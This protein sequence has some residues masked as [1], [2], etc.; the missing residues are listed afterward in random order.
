VTIFLCHAIDLPPDQGSVAA[1]AVDTLVRGAPAGRI[2]VE[3]PALV[4]LY[5]GILAD[6]ARRP[7]AEVIVHVLGNVDTDAILT[8]IGSETASRELRERLTAELNAHSPRHGAHAKPPDLPPREPAPTRGMHFWESEPVAAPVEAATACP[9]GIFK[10]KP[11]DS[12]VRI[13][14]VV[15]NA[16]KVAFAPVTDQLLL[17]ASRGI[18]HARY[19]G[20]ANVTDRLVEWLG[21]GL[22]VHA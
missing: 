5:R 18:E 14:S 15:G 7:I 16:E 8:S 12:M 4:D 17:D 22:P 19:F 13:D 3:A 2:I 21:A 10:Q 1:E 6:A 9:D 11:N 20:N